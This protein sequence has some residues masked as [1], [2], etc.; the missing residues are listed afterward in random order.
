MLSGLIYGLLASFLWGFSYV[1]PSLLETFEP[2]EIF[3][4]RNLGFGFLSFLIYSFLHKKENRAVSIGGCRIGTASI[5][6]LALVGYIVYDYLD[7][8]NLRISGPQNVG[9]FYGITLL[10]FQL[11]KKYVSGPERPSKTEVIRLFIMIQGLM[12]LFWGVWDFSVA[13]KWLMGTV[14]SITQGLMW[15]WFTSSISHCSQKESESELSSVIITAKIGNV[16]FLFSLICTCMYIFL[17]DGSF[18]AFFGK[19]TLMEWGRFFVV[20]FITGGSF[21]WLAAELWCRA[22]RTVPYQ[23]LSHLLL[24]DVVAGRVLSHFSGEI[25]LGFLHLFGAFILLGGWTVLFKL[26]RT[27][28][29]A[30]VSV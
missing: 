25:P 6:Q 7:I 26:K 29:N 4:G 5:V 24:A 27:K 13:E 12:L 22:S 23:I 17:Q 21:A 15:I 19:H 30:Q 16:C 28:I 3:L 18:V 9:L 8:I 11:L 20:S 2:S 10:T 1:A 14:I